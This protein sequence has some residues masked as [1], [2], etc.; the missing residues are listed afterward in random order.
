VP[1]FAA[2]FN[3]HI[4]R[5]FNAVVREK[6]RR[7]KPRFSL[8]MIRDDGAAGSIGAAGGRCRSGTER[9]VLSITPGFQPDARPDEKTIFIRNVFQNL[10][11]FSPNP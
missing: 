1:L 7:T 9:G 10:A 5:P 6:R 11:K 2:P 3:E 8:K 4:D